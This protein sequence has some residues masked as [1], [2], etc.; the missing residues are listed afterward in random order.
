MRRSS[1]ASW[2][3]ILLMTFT[4]RP[5]LLGIEIMD[6]D[7][8]ESFT[9]YDHPKVTDLQK[10]GRFSM[11]KVRAIFDGY[12]LERIVRVMPKQVTKA[13][14]NLML[15]R[16]S[17]RRSERAAPGREI[18]HREQPGQPAAHADLAVGPAA[19]GPGGFS[20]G[21]CRLSAA[22]A[23]AAISCPRRWD[24]CCWAIS[25]GCCPVSSWLP[26]TRWHH[27]RRC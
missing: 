16:R 15:T 20:A 18:F 2:A 24:C 22:C 7:A 26:Y 25:P 17:G 13:P 10:A 3:L 4:S 27:R 21:L 9:V 8:D 11:A 5:R 23:T 19:A 6:D 14:N 1:R 12:D